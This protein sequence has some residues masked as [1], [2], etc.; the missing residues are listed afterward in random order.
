ME[1]SAQHLLNTIE[2]KFKELETEQ[3]SLLKQMYFDELAA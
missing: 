2:E 1:G 3:D